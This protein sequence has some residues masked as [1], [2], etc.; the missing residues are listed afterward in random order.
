M[1]FIA[2]WIDPKANQGIQ[3][4][5]VN[6]AEEYWQAGTAVRLATPKPIQK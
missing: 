3:D 1:Y 6:K 4:E 5:F 2:Q